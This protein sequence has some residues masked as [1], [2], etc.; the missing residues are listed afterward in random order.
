MCFNWVGFTF[1][2]IYIQNFPEQ[3]VGE[4]WNKVLE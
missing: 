3:L 4:E 2:G 1:Q